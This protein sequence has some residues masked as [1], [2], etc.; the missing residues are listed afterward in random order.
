VHAAYSVNNVGAALEP[1]AT[2]VDRCQQRRGK[3]R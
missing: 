1:A 3:R 2:A